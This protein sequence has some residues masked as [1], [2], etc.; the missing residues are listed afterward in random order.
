MGITY[1]PFAGKM[2]TLPSDGTTSPIHPNM[3]FQT[4]RQSSPAGRAKTK[5]KD[6][7]SISSCFSCPL[8]VAAADHDVLVAG[9]VGPYGAC[10]GDGSEYTGDYVD[11][12]MTG[13]QLESWH[14]ERIK[15]LCEAGVDLLAVETI[16]SVV[17]AKG[18]A[19]IKIIFFMSA[20]MGRLLTSFATSGGS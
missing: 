4:G 19:N 15:R 14:F 17:E 1:H 7:N 6:A 13:K 18:K 9:S 11:T 2:A 8:C 20:L 5:T 10:L 3:A 12:K 16:P